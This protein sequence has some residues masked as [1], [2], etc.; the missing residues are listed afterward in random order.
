MKIE[1]FK[2]ET[3]EKMS[4]P[5]EAGEGYPY[6]KGWVFIHTISGKKLNK[7]IREDDKHF[8]SL[9]CIGKYIEELFKVEKE[10]KEVK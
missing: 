7:M 5:A 3:C 8:C 4:E 1:Q 2:C 10:Q 6:N 9:K